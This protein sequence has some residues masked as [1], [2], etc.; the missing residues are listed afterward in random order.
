MQGYALAWAFI[1]DCQNFLKG[2]GWG[3]GGLWGTPPPPSGDP[4]LLEAPKAQNKFFGLN[5]RSGPRENFPNHFRGGG[6][7]SKPPPA[8]GTPPPPGDA[9]LLSKTLGKGLHYLV[10]ATGEPYV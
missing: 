4:E 2:G 5:S 8:M 3:G 10:Q 7:G 1:R 9:E 6:G